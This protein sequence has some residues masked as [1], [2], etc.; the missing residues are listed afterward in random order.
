MLFRSLLHG[1]SWNAHFPS[2]IESILWK[3]SCFGLVCF[4][5][6]TVGFIRACGK[7]W[8]EANIAVSWNMRFTGSGKGI[9][10]LYKQFRKDFALELQNQARDGESVET[11]SRGW[12]FIADITNLMLFLHFLCMAYFAVESFIS[13]RNLP[14]GAYDLPPGL[15][16]IPHI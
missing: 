9:G 8:P 7:Q 3:I 6:S 2:T 14:E 16:I 12:R 11:P 5:G 4:T 1:L 10:E 15:Q 13:I